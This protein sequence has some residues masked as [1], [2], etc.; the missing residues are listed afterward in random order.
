VAVGLVAL[1]GVAAGGRAADREDRFRIGIENASARVGEKAIIVA[2]ITTQAGFKITDSYRH[3]ILHLVAS[4][5]IELPGKVVR[6]SVQDGRVVFFVGVTPKK[7]GTHTVTGLFRFSVHNG[8][9]VDITSAPFEAT[10]TA[11]E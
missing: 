6:G 7:A 8:Q 1:T 3:R 2:T 11:T 5:G 4:E 10:V 9:Q